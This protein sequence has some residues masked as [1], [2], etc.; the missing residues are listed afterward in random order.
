MPRR[1]RQDSQSPTGAGRVANT[2]PPLPLLS[3][4]QPLQARR[5]KKASELMPA[6]GEDGGALRAVVL[7][8]PS[9]PTKEALQPL[10][11]CWEAGHRRAAENRLV[12]PYLQYKTVYDMQAGSRSASVSSV[13][14]GGGGE[15][16][17]PP[18]AA[19]P[20]S[21]EDGGAS[22][23]FDSRFESGNLL[24]ARRVTCAYKNKFQFPAAPA[25]SEY[26]LSL[27]LD[28]NTD[29]HVQWYYF[30]VENVQSAGQCVRFTI[31]GFKK[32][33]S[34]YNYGM[35]PAVY[36]TKEAN[37]PAHRGWC[38]DGST[39]VCYYRTGDSY[40]DKNTRRK[41]F[42][43][44]SFT[45]TFKHADDTCYF[46]YSV[47]YTYT[48]LRRDLLKLEAHPERRLFF[49]RRTLCTTFGDNE[50]DL[51]T[52]TGPSGDRAAVQARP[53]VVITARVHPGETVA[54]FIMQGIL[55]FLTGP[56]PEAEA[57]R[58]TFVFKIV[59]MLNPD[60]VINGNYR[61]SLAG[62]DLNR[63]WGDA[64]DVYHPTVHWTKQMVRA[65]VRACG[66]VCAGREDGW[67]VHVHRLLLSMFPA[68]S[69]SPVPQHCSV[70][71]DIVALFSLSQRAKPPS[72]LAPPD[73][74]S[75]LN[76]LTYT[77]ILRHLPSSVHVSFAL[78]QSE[79]VSLPFSQRLHRPPPH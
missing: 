74:P 25:T 15:P 3:A 65:C 67:A 43:A 53:A 18:T 17:A 32:S 44:L 45:H 58:D 57:L 10:G 2:A 11:A 55:D 29:G 42:Y 72:S 62:C 19:V 52:I 20:T 63:R 76:I 54:S 77:R 21:T 16:P 48:D 39:E 73:Y 70:L 69:P 5:I 75:H 71:L 46:A 79:N 36:S 7:E 8:A 66:C 61:C 60:G 30:S 27:R 68:L 56:S 23:V 41:H 13:A 31:K 78:L 64:S 34:L 12:G 50:C 24:R 38:R 1:A 26:E 22:L 37:G 4:P 28:T 51:V 59:P 14:A 49:R 47:P 40:V 9:V 33:D 35:L 6:K